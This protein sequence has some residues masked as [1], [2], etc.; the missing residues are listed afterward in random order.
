M[1]TFAHAVMVD[2]S[3]IMFV[4]VSLAV[5]TAVANKIHDAVYIGRGVPGY[6]TLI[7]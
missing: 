4:S 7:E 1:P 5:F 6:K 2:A 3:V